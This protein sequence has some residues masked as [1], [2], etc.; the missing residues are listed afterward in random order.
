MLERPTSLLR[1]SPGSRTLRA[2]LLPRSGRVQHDRLRSLPAVDG[3]WRRSRRPAAPRTRRLRRRRPPGRVSAPVA[4]CFSLVPLSQR[5]AGQR[6][7]R[8]WRWSSSAFARTVD[9]PEPTAP[10]SHC[11]GTARSDCGPAQIEVPVRISLATWLLP[12]FHDRGSEEVV[13]SPARLPPSLTSQATRAGRSRARNRPP[14]AAG[15]RRRPVPPP[16]LTGACLAGSRRVTCSSRGRSERFALTPRRP[17][18]VCVA[19][20]SSTANLC[21]ARLTICSAIAAS[22]GSPRRC[23]AS[24]ARDLRLSSPST[25]A[26]R[27]SGRH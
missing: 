4:T 14:R 27:Q 12:R 20:A 11:P 22:R 19:S 25:V 13:V 9:P 26:D 1:P 5:P 10:P 21:P 6:R 15:A 16:S 2:D 3:T 23:V 7:R 24:V 8:R 17:A 18:S